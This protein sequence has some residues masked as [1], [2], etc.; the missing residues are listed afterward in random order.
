MTLGTTPQVGDRLGNLVRRRSVRAAR[1][2]STSARHR[3]DGLLALYST[4]ALVAESG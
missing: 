1:T 4:M 2:T 3:A